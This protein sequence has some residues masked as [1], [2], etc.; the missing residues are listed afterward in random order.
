MSKLKKYQLSEILVIDDDEENVIS[1][2]NFGL[3]TILYVNL[4]GVKK[5]LSKYG[6]EQYRI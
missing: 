3:H 5:E 4:G 2:K 6:I 1:A